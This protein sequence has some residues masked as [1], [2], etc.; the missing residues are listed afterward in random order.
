MATQL[1]IE[2]G[3]AKSLVR[4]ETFAVVLA[5]DVIISERPCPAQLR[6]VYEW[7]GQPVI[8]LMEVAAGEFRLRHCQ[9]QKGDQFPWNSRRVQNQ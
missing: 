6:S 3:R 5:D 7:S 4:D 8:A 1:R 2:L 9:W